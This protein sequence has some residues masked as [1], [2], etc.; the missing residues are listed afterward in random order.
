MRSPKASRDL[1]GPQ[2][3]IAIVMA[4]LIVALAASAA[5][6]AAWQQGL[7][8][9]Q[10][11]NR[12]SQAQA[13]AITTAGIDFARAVL[14]K[15]L[16]D[17]ASAQTDNLE[18]PWA[19]YALSVPVEGG[20]VQGKIED[21]QGR[22]NLNNAAANNDQ[23][24]VLQNLLRALKLEPELAAAVHDW[25]DSD[26]ATEFPGGAEDLDYLSR[27]E[28]YRTAGR[29]IIDVEELRFV[30][31]FDDEVI[32]KLRP[33]V[34][35]LPA[36]PGTATP[37]NVNTASKEVLTA[38]FNDVTVAEKLIQAREQS[39]PNGGPFKSDA[40]FAARTQGIVPQ[41]EPGKGT[42]NREPG[43]ETAQAIQPTLAR[44]PSTAPS[45][46]HSAAKWPWESVRPRTRPA[47]ADRPAGFLLASFSREEDGEHEAR[48]DIAQAEQPPQ[49]PPAQGA[50]QNPPPSNGNSPG[51]N[52]PGTN[53]PGANPPGANPPGGGANPP[54]AFPQ[55]GT[56]YAV[57]SSYFLVSARSQFGSVQQG[58]EALV[59]R[60][61]Q[62]WPRV[63]MLRPMVN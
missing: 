5:A 42:G 57:T 13:L 54:A 17:P 16:Q 29:V 6:F 39:G 46:S 9:R 11:E 51:V 52:P 25:I 1:T 22:Y 27:R 4:I 41:P 18:E 61:G 59:Q 23:M 2:R 30:K 62:G 21:L 45:T 56:D 3:G 14:A 34:C 26:D 33:F 47:L 31:G 10:T 48:L 40:D 44:R 8:I 38:L 36:Q 24:I 37:I 15:D 12:V 35:A 60:T 32:K 49:Q 63:L 7:W 28:P 53:P 58:V 50:P 19:K 20:Q 55:L 43:R